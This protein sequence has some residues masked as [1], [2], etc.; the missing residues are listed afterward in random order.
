L[1]A[2]GL[3]VAVAT[4]DDHDPAVATLAGLGVLDLVDMVV[5]A[6]DM[7]TKPA[8]DPVLAICA[9]LNIAPAD[10]MV[11]GD[12]RVDLQMGRAAGAGLLVGVA[13]G[14]YAAEELAPEADVVLDSIADL[15]LM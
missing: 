12:S 5:G 6:D 1:R 15:L 3:R 4:A 14:L 9:H 13:S 2:R 10:A 7:P 8:P 11:V